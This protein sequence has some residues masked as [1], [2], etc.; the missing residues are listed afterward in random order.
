MNNYDLTLYVL[1][2]FSH[3]SNII[4][5]GQ[6]RSLILHRQTL[7]SN[8]LHMVRLIKMGLAAFLYTLQYIPQLDCMATL[9]DTLIL[10]FYNN[11]VQSLLSL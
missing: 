6:T 10:N 3:M 7:T 11:V 2:R 5:I 9:N 1:N 8:V 4:S